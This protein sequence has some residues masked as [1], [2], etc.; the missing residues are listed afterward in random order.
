MLIFEDFTKDTLKK[1]TGYI[2]KSPLRCSDVSVG[3]FLMWN[4]GSNLQFAVINE[5]F[6]SKRDYG[7]ETVFSFPYG[8][9]EN[10]AIDQLIEYVEQNDLALTFFGV[11]DIL[12]EK[13]KENPKLSAVMGGYER[14][15]SDYIYDFEEMRTFSGGKFAGQRNHINKFI[16]NY[17]LP[18]FSAITEDDLPKI[19]EFLLEYKEEHTQRFYIEESELTSTEMMLEIFEQFGLYGG[20]LEINGKI[21]GFSIGEIVGDTLIIHIEK[22]LRKYQG[23]YPTLFNRF[24]NFVYENSGENLKFVNR[25]D[26]SGDLGLRTSKLQYKPVFLL[27]KNLVKVNSPLYSI[28]KHPTLIGDGIVLDQITEEDKQNYF[29][30]CVDDEVNKLWGYDYKTDVFLPSDVNEDTFFD[31]QKHDNSIGYSINFAIRET[32]GGELLG[33]TIVYNFTYNRNAEMGCRLL[34]KAWGK[35]LGQKA[36]Q[37]TLEWAEK[38]LNA[39]ITGKCFKQNIPSFKMITYSGLTLF[40]EDEDFYYFKRKNIE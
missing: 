19:N 20:K 8:K 2:K 35:K 36:Y 33:E 28:K 29:A 22:A 10:G 30:L 24:V 15:W 32:I 25:E 4:K 1:Y 23:A 13:I 37:M 14:R 27:N 16:K 12:F 18:E 9:D 40:K 39:R 21:I 11:N 3:S 34:K 6:I 17:G 26:D 38:V 7:D 31:V 5:T